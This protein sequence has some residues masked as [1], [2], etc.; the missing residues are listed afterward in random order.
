[1]N[2]KIL[3]II[4]TSLII[5]AIAIIAI[6]LVSDLNK[7]TTIKNEVKEIN[8]YINLNQNANDKI[9]EV[10]TRRQIT[11]GKYKNIENDI[12]EYYQALYSD[13]QNY[14]FLIASDTFAS[15]LSSDNLNEDKPSFI[16]SKD[17]LQNTKAQIEEYYNKLK[18]YLNS[19]ATKL[20]YITNQKLDTYYRNFYLELTEMVN[21]EELLKELDKTYQD[22]LS[23]INIY[24]EALDFLIANKGHWSIKNNVIIFDDNLL[25]EGYLKITDK[26][27]VSEN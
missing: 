5:I 23:K 22:T 21:K 12:K 10:L 8:K 13:I 4:I 11:K 1:M 16:K 20:N 3:T 2:K 18:D 25:Y 15:Y 9:N 27:E 26:L 7:E 24:N 6:K 14:T 19:E 17:N